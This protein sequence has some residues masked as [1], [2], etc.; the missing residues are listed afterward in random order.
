M[1]AVKAI[2][3]DGGREAGGERGFVAQQAKQLQAKALAGVLLG[4][5]DIEIGRE[6]RG[7]EAVGMDDPEGEDETLVVTTHQI[8]P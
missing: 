7:R 4:G 6:V 2:G 1:V 5:A 3:D 8:T